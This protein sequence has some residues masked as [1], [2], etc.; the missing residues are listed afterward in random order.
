[1]I[2]AKH[3]FDKRTVVVQNQAISVGVVSLLSR[4]TIYILVLFS[5]KYLNDAKIRLSLL[6]N[7]YVPVSHEFT[8]SGVDSSC[9]IAKLS[10][11]HPTVIALI[12]RDS[13]L[14][15]LARA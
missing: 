14:G 6:S 1:M 9:R 13:S 4:I 2:L 12:L 10:F 3:L 15:K 11:L 5:S 7:Q 8:Q